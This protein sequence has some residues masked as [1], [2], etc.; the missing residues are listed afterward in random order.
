MSKDLY[1]ARLGM[2]EINRIVSSGSC[3]T[4]AIGEVIDLSAALRLAGVDNPTIGLAQEQI[5]ERS[6]DN[7]RRDRSLFQVST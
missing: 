2:P 1:R 4:P 3:P 6:Q 5:Q 7:W